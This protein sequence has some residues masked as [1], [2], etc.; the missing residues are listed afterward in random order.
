M[1]DPLDESAIAGLAHEVRTASGRL[2]R[3]L[4]DRGARM[5]LTPSQS[6]VLGIIDR[7]GTATVTALANE[8]GIRPQSVGATIAALEEHGLV[9]ATPD[10]ADGRQ[11]V[12]ATTAKARDLVAV[13]RGLREDWLA[14]RISTV[15]TPAEQRRLQDAV[16]LLN[17]L[18]AD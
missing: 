15:L 13:S 18:V 16:T 4:R 9:T 5:G 8:I 17:R 7:N 14:E 1:T 11:R 3:A 10:P 6:E 12:I 2:T